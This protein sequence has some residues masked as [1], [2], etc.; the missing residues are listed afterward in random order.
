MCIP[1]FAMNPLAHRILCVMDKSYGHGRQISFRDF[2]E[3]VAIFNEHA[4]RSEKL[5]FAFR[6]YDQKDDDVLDEEEILHVLK[7]MV[8]QHLTSD[9][10]Q[11]L[12][13]Q[14][15]TDAHADHRQIFLPQF[16]HVRTVSFIKIR[17]SRWCRCFQRLM[18]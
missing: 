2:V 9:E 15:F 17:S 4:S 3:A 12:V 6:V 1:E 10:L 11:P 16:E 8:G 5:R 18:Y 14:I 7:S 13:D